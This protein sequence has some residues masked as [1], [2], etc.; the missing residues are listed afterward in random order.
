MAT[1]PTNNPLGGIGNYLDYA[2]EQEKKDKENPQS[3]E[4][5]IF[6]FD[7]LKMY[8][9]EPYAL[10][11]K[12]TIYEPTIG[13]IIEFGE[14]EY[15]S[16]LTSLTCIP[17]DMKSQL[18]DI[19]INYMEVSDFEL[20]MMLSRA[21]T[22]SQTKLLFGDLDLSAMQPYV[23]QV[24]DETVLYN[25]ETEQMIDK[26]VYMKMCEYLRLMHGMGKPKVENAVNETTRR[27]LIQLDREKKAKAQKEPYKSQLKTLISAM[28]R[29]P[30]FKYKRDELKQC[31]I[32]EFMDTVQGAQIY[33]QATALLQGSFSG[34]IDTSKL[35]KEQMNWLRGAND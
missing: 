34:M 19:G 32:Y 15:Y 23:N 7:E 14:R 25:P 28:M 31:G 10:T 3:K 18:E 8:F 4:K 29:Y 21:F 33:V 16:A 17:S 1:T 2:K 9:C 12:I 26:F 13:D 5:N 20:F 11:D 24:N 6:Y 22:P 35:P 30:G 27:I